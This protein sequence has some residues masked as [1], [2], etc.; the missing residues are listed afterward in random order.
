[1]PP[2]Q[3]VALA[4]VVSAHGHIMW[5]VCGVNFVWLQAC[6]GLALNTHPALVKSTALLHIP[7]QY[8][9][10]RHCTGAEGQI[11]LRLVKDLAAAGEKV[12]A[13]ETQLRSLGAADQSIEQQ[14]SLCSCRVLEERDAPC[15]GRLRGK[16]AAAGSV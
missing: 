6:S 1:M 3:Q 10:S 14:S 2:T 5:R 4:V 13:G 12:V 9:Y 7:F 16:W 15:F 8:V 11:A